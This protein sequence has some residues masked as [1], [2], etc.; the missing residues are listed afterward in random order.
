LRDMLDVGARVALG[1][2]GSRARQGR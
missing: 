2:E 1:V